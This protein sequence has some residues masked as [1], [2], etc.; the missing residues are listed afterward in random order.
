MPDPATVSNSSCLIALELIGRLD[1]LRELYATVTVPSAVAYECGSRLP[2]WFY[3][4]PVQNQV[5]VRTLRLGLGPG[6]SEAIVLASEVS[7]ARLIL[8]DRKVRR[9]AQQLGLP[10]TGTLAFLLRA[11]QQALIPNVRD[12]LDDL[13]AAEFRISDALIQDTLRRAGE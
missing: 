11:K 5:M 12:V 6:E 8:D 13:A 10:V 3:V 1:L 9:I 4:Q 2:P 7:A